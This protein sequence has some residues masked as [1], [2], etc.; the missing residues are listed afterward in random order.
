MKGRFC[1]NGYDFLERCERFMKPYVEDYLDRR[2]K[3]IR[4]Y[5]QTESGKYARSVGN[6]KRRCL[7]KESILKLTDEEKK[8]IGKFYKN[9][10][11]GY[12]VDHIIPVSKGGLHC[13]SNLQYL[14][15]TENRQKWCKIIN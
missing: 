2:R 4:D 5:F 12:E 14:T 7:M 9:C 15:V 10:P 3:K 1:S 13:L 11:K 8:L 6:T